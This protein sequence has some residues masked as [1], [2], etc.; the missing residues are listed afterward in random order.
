[1]KVTGIPV[2]D[3]LGEDTTVVL[4]VSGLTVWVKAVV[5]L[6]MKLGSPEYEAVIECGPT[7]RVP[8]LT[9]AWPA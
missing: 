6:A 2:S 4:V 8:I 9:V 7:A 5:E 3:G 1:V